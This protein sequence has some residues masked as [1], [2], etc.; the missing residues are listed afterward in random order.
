MIHALWKA[1]L[2]LYADTKYLI[3]LDSIPV[4]TVYSDKIIIDGIL[5]YSDHVNTLI[6]ITF[7][8]SPKFL[9]SIVYLL[10]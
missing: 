5:L 1:W 2:L 4:S 7:I 6:Y 9:L 3:R 10:S 8:V